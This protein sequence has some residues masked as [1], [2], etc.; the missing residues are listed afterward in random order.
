MQT[1][2]GD[3]IPSTKNLVGANVELVEAEN[4]EYILKNA[5]AKIKDDYDYIIIDCPP[6]LELLTVNAF[7]AADSVLI[8]VQCEYY[9]LEGL[10]DLLGTIKLVNKRINPVLDIEGIVL[11]MYDSRTKLSEEVAS[12]LRE[13]FGDKVYKTTIPRNIRISESPSH[14]LPVLGY[15]KY[16]KGARAYL[17]LANELIKAQD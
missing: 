6:S 15:D 16:S 14:G 1:K 3:V 5:L 9:A 12:Q 8:P 4:R 17:H 7:C 10:A 13:H 11:T 2:F